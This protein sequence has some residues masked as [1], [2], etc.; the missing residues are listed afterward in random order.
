[1]IIAK[2]MSSHLVNPE[3]MRTLDQLSGPEL[4][5]K[6]RQ[7]LKLKLGQDIASA[8][9]KSGTKIDACGDLDRI[10]AELKRPPLTE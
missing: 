3:I 10:L 1:M 6:E 9:E 4:P 7:A 8:L 5:V 2:S